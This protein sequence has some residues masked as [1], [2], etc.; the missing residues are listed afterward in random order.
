[1]GSHFVIKTDHKHL[2]YLLEQ[3]IT[4]PNQYT[5]VCKLMSF[6]YEI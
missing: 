3:K 4:T 6:D 5:W 1:M 2:K